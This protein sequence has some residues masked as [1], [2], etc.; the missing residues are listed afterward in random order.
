MRVVCHNPKHYVQDCELKQYTH[1]Y[2]VTHNPH[3][4]VYDIYEAQ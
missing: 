4:C 2:S 1:C 3:E